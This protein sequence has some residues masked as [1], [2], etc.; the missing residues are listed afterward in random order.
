VSSLSQRSKLPGRVAPSMR[1]E[2]RG[3]SI[4]YRAVG[5]G[6]PFLML[7]GS[8][9]DGARV[10]AEVDPAFRG[11]TGWR[12]VYPD[13]PGHGATPGS[14]RIRT[15]DDYLEVLVEFVD[16][17]FAGRNFALG[18]TSFGAYL[19]LGIA[20]TQ[21]ERVDG[22]LLSVPEVNFS[23]R[24]E[25]REQRRAGS[26]GRSPP[27]AAR[28]SR[29][30]TEDT[31]WLE[32]LPYRDLTVDLY[33]AAKPFP[34]PTLFLFGRQDAAFRYREYAKLLP[35]FPRATFAVLDG[36]GHALWRD[37]RRLASALVRD[38]LDRVEAGTR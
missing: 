15:I 1:C 20:R 11:R 3:I 23:P 9:G 19:A 10:R 2:L 27:E 29:G 28:V 8:P 34:A 36:A 4:H 31:R 6:R 16:T 26:S 7:H 25:R 24:E 33:H 35:G 13:L 38:W 32:S 21:G 5:R 37:R 30:Y 18:G 17:L 14:A 22:L 12:R